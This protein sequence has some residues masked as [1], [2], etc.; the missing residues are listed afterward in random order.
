M[1]IY[2]VHLFGLVLIGIMVLQLGSIIQQF[3]L[4]IIDLLVIMLLLV[5]FIG[6][7]F[8]NNRIMICF[9][10]TKAGRLCNWP[11]TFS[12]WYS[13]TACP[14]GGTNPSSA[15]TISSYTRTLASGYFTTASNSQDVFYMAIGY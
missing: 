2:I 12:T 11:L 13:I 1:R 5:L 10:Y 6:F 3:K 4:L 14:N 9:G 7:A 15:T 8:V